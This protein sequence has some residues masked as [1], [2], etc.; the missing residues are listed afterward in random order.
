M[1]IFVCV[2]QVPDDYVEVHLNPTTGT[3]DVEGID[4]VN[5]AFDTYAVEM[6]VRAVEAHG[7]SVTVAAIG[8]EKCQNGL[9]NLIAVGANKAVLLSD[10]AL[11]D[12][13]EAATASALA[14]LIAKCEANQGESFDLIFCGKESTDE[15]SAQVGAML[16]ETLK[17]PFVSSVVEVEPVEGGVKAKQETESGYAVYEMALPAVLTVAKPAYDPRYPTIKSKM[18]A[19]KATIPMLTA[20]DAGAVKQ[21]NRVTCLGYSEPAKRQAG[22]RIQEK[23]AADA[24]AK[25]V[26][27]MAEAKAI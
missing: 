19:R 27:M 24:V 7:G 5:N 22:V 12:L 9:K 8:P 17:A 3:P 18:A 4:Q 16:S 26:A 14:S 15:I 13:D 20:A 6:A 2:K 21:D 10:P 25:A 1:N 23:E 11:L